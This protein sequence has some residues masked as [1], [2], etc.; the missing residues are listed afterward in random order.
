[1]E[2][3]QKDWSTLKASNS[4]RRS[5]KKNNMLELNKQRF[6]PVESFVTLTSTYGNYT[7]IRFLIFISFK[8]RGSG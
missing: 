7:F 3:K 1:M 6:A 4:K 5:H 8:F 2:D